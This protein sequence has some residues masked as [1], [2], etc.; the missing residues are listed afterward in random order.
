[1]NIQNIRN[2]YPKSYKALKQWLKA[3]MLKA[4]QDVQ[5]RAAFGYTANNFKPETVVEALDMDGAI[6]Q[7]CSSPQGVRTLYDFFDNNQIYMIIHKT[8]TFWEALVNTGV[9]KAGYNR[10]EAEE[11]GYLDCFHQLEKQLL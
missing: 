11:Y 2:T 10:S 7:M 1:M 4:M 3:E 8:D 5:Q 6:T 9:S